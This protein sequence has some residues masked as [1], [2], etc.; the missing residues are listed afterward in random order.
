[1]PD[2]S[3]FTT[4]NILEDMLTQVDD[5][6][7]KGEGSVIGSALGPTAW[8]LEGVYE[9]LSQ[10]QQNAYAPT[11]VGD[12]LDLITNGRGIIRKP[13][14]PAIRQGTFNIAIEAG[15]RFSTV[16]EEDSLIYDSG[17]L[18][19][20]SGETWIYEM[21]CE[22]PG[23]EGNAYTG[24]LIPIT[25]IEGLTSAT[26]GEV[27][28][29]GE[30]EESDDSL[31]QRYDESFQAPAFGGNISAYRQL[32][33]SLQGVGAVQVYPA[34]EGG[35][36]VL[37]SILATDLTPA[38]EDTVKRV[39]GIV[40]P[41]EKGGN[42]PSPLGFGFAPIGAAV[43]ITTAQSV[44]INVAAT[45]ETDPSASSDVSSYKDQITANVQSY[46]D[47]VNEM[48]GNALKGYTIEYPVTIY[49]ARIIAAIITVNGIINVSGVTINGQ[50]NDLHLTET[51]Q[52]QQVAALG[53]VTIS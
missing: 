34:W 45:I 33:L 7:D 12:S 5:S 42:T 19:S 53:E 40:C 8:Y 16:N 25:N 11:A 4:Q 35:G 27:I 31:R 39:Q 37:C 36:T 14:T 23:A 41:P 43:T 17:N 18:I 3:D 47:S 10:V 15:S 26:L 13:A 48:W 32:I 49:I 44:I 52:L 22:T 1:M 2:F 29:P 30:D 6:F 24:E 46:I 38:S 21:T 28:T 50:S 9:E 51:A 20:G